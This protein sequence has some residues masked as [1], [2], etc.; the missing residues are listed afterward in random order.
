MNKVVHTGAKTQL[1]GL[2]EGFARPRYHVGIELA[3]KN[4]PI[5]PASWHITIET[6]NLIILSAFI[7]INPVN[8]V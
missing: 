5:M 7:I 4:E 1:G 3:V 2:K 6:M 8:K